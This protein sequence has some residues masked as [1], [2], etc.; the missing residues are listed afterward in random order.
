MD[1]LVA[2]FV[3]E[4]DPIVFGEPVRVRVRLHNPTLRH[5]RI[6]V[7]VDPVTVRSSPPR[8]GGGTVFQSS[9]SR[10]VLDIVSRDY[11]VRA[12]VVRNRRRV[13]LDLGRE[14][15]FPSGS[16]REIVL[17]LGKVDNDR[18]LAGFRSY[19]VGGQL[20]AAG[21]EVGGL[22]RFEAIRIADATLR[23][24]RPGYE[25]LEKDPVRRIGQAVE[26]GAFVHLLTATALVP[27]A[28]RRDATD[29]LVAALGHRSSLDWALF[30]CLQ[31]ITGIE[32]GRDVDAWR[33]WW[34]RV[35]ETYFGP[36]AGRYPGR[37][38]VFAD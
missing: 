31:Y 7:R 11:D 14:L 8:P 22:R 2:W 13:H 18:P 38:P 35:R 9:P 6:H 28:R 3:P 37:K 1:S 30:S 29:K 20:R 24:F 32:L 23:S 25:H 16:T 5:I 27:Y 21:I 10:F 26:K 36:V 15:D 4:R 17:D 19:T 33:A 34:P 12:Q